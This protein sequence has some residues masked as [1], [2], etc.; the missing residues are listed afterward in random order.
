MFGCSDEKYKS[1]NN[2]NGSFIWKLFL[3]SKNTSKAV[4]KFPENQVERCGSSLRVGTIG[5]T[6]VF[7]ALSGKLGPKKG[8]SLK[9]YGHRHVNLGRVEI[10]I[11]CLILSTFRNSIT[12]K[13]L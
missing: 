8:S 11:N 3:S 7:N 1:L 2:T 5:N 9:N 4:E 6:K 12:F 10:I 13:T